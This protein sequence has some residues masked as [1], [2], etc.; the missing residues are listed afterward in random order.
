M[1]L[2]VEHL[3]EQDDADYAHDAC[4]DQ[5]PRHAQGEQHSGHQGGDAVAHVYSEPDRGGVGR[6]ELEEPFFCG[7]WETSTMKL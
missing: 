7:G 6:R 5:V 1:Q 3:V 4:R 2:T